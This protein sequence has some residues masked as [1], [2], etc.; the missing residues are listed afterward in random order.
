MHTANAQTI[1]RVNHATAALRAAQTGATWGLAYDS[2][3]VALAASSSGDVVWIAAGT[4]KRATF[5]ADSDDTNERDLSFE[6]PDGVKVYGG[7][8]GTETN[9]TPDNPDTEADED[10][11]AKNEDGNFTNVTILSGDL[12]GDDDNLTYPVRGDEESSSNY[13]TR[14][15]TWLAKRNDN[16]KSVV[17]ILRHANYE[18]YLTLLAA[19]RAGRS[20]DE[21]LLPTA[22][23]SVLDGVTVTRGYG[24]SGGG[25]YASRGSSP[26]ITH[27]TFTNNTAGE[28]G[29]IYSS[30]YSSSTISYCTFENNTVK[31]GV[32]RGSAIF[33]DSSTITNC[34]FTNNSGGAISTA[35]STTIT[36][37][38]FTNNSGV[39][40][41]TGS[42][43]TISHCTFTN[44]SGVAISTVLSTIS[45]CTFTNNSGGA[46]NTGS[47]SISYCTFENNTASSGGAIYSGSSSTIS[48]CTFTNNMA[49]GQYS[50][51]G[52]ILAQSSSDSY[53]SST[54]SH[55]TCLLYTSPSPRDRQKSRMPSSA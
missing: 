26:T 22:V 14:S 44:N 13:R 2:L 6:I 11:R 37:C 5:T 42:Y 32:P 30:S 33:A 10:T 40:I 54:I 18:D 53:H 12:S 49:T 47:S 21:P 51:G 36:N 43:S 31:G 50:N 34:T 55:C 25:V 38:T 41:N 29:A 24:S 4:Y 15:N 52:A 35:L 23:G 3:H 20:E 16:S 17:K 8:A 27:C 45:H 28:G 7:F 48:H 9:F 1:R 46:I 39:A 19:Y